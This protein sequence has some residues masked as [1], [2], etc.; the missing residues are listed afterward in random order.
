M[1]RKRD[2]SELSQESSGIPGK[3]PRGRSLSGG[4]DSD[5]D[6]V[7]VVDPE[8]EGD[9]EMEGEPE[10]MEEWNQEENQDQP[11]ETTRSYAEAA[12]IRPKLFVYTTE[13]AQSP[14]RFQA[15]LEFKKAL[16]SR[17]YKAIM[18]KTISP[19]INCDQI[20]YDREQGHAVITC[21]NKQSAFW[22]KVVIS[23]IKVDN[24]PFRA[25]EEGER[26]KK[27]EMRLFVPDTY[28]NLQAEEVKNAVLHYNQE[29]ADTFEVRKEVALKTGR[30]L[31]I[32]VGPVFFQYCKERKGKINFMMGPLECN[33]P[34]VHRAA[35]KTSDGQPKDAIEPPS[36]TKTKQIGKEPRKVLLAGREQRTGDPNFQTKQTKPDHRTRSPNEANAQKTVRQRVGGVRELEVEGAGNPTGDDKG[37]KAEKGED[38][39]RSGAPSREEEWQKV[40]RKKH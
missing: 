14:M 29:G 27:F 7:V 36:Q 40:Q 31:E 16:A 1:N 19:D 6:G 24:V 3:S 37:N 28:Q 23:S 35:R 25:W 34:G 20:V 5:T 33:P 15:F 13:H 32:E 9:S 39:G 22:L 30:G 12:I 21:H 38:H 18:D 8:I 17:F 10:K 4:S 11:D 26:P 2:S